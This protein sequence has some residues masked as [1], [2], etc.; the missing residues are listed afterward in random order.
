MAL[1][2][3]PELVMAIHPRTKRTKPNSSITSDCFRDKFPL[4]L[5]RRFIIEV[6]EKLKSK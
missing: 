6:V 3:I 5:K 2:T 4:S 1:G